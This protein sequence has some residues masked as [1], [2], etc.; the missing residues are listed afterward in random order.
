VAQPDFICWNSASWVL[1]TLRGD[2]M[3]NWDLSVIK[4]TSIRE[5]LKLQFRLE[6]SNTFNRCMF[7]AP[8]VTTT[9][10]NYG[11][12]TSQANTPRLMQVSLKIIF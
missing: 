8:D 12:V 9:D 1:S 6:T 2:A 4:D 10:A 3:N 7:S 5:N 11:V